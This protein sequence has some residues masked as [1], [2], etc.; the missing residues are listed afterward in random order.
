VGRALVKPKKLSGRR[1]FQTRLKGEIVDGGKGRDLGVQAAEEK[2]EG[3]T[4]GG[5]SQEIHLFY[6]GLREIRTGGKQEFHEER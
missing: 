6:S 2:K 4:T 1:E 3:V 5:G